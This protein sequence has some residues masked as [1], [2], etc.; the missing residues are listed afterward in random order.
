M[1]VNLQC[2]F[3]EREQA[4]SAGAMWDAKR[5]VWYVKGVTDYRPFLK[6]LPNGPPRNQ[7]K[8][9][10]LTVGA[11][12]DPA[13]L[14]DSPIPPWQENGTDMPELQKLESESQPSDG[15]SPNGAVCT[16][17]GVGVHVALPQLRTL[18]AGDGG[19]GAGAG[20]LGA[21][22]TEAKVIALIAARQR[23]G[24][25][26]Y[27]TTVADNPL[28]LRDWLQHQLEELLDAAVY[29]QRAIDGLDAHQMLALPVRG[30]E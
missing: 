25:A 2:P 11:K 12:F 3:S 19:A 22:G 10:K 7:S 13:L 23:L 1:R 14:S 16:S 30:D 18:P 8:K 28:P 4:K 27:G 6:W 9:P 15:G 26:K 24:V 29:C 17:T 21:T 5:R 20:G